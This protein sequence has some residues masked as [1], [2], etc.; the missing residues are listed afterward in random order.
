MKLED[1]AVGQ[2]VRIRQ[3]GD[4]ERE[5]GLTV[6]GNISSPAYLFL[7][8]MRF[9]CGWEGVVA[10]LQR[11]GCIIL[12]GRDGRPLSGYVITPQMLEPAEVEPASVC[13]DSLKAIL[14]G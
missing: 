3:W 6:R 11:D 10:E 7:K 1:I 2:K 13:A 4:M 9:M 5:Y 14:M 8:N 12:H